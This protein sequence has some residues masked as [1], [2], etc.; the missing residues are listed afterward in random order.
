MKIPVKA[1]EEVG[2]RILVE[3]RIAC[4]RMEVSHIPEPNE[5][6]FN[7]PNISGPEYTKKSAGGLCPQVH[8]Y[9]EHHQH[10]RSPVQPPRQVCGI[11]GK[12]PGFSVKPYNVS[13]AFRQ[14]GDPSESD[15]EPEIDYLVYFL[16]ATLQGLNPEI[17]RL[18][19]VML[20]EMENFA[21]IIAL[22]AQK[23]CIRFH[24]ETTFPVESAGT[25]TSNNRQH[26][27]PTETAEPGGQQHGEPSPSASV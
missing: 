26:Q 14:I 13:Q 2:F 17:D 7:P 21:A 27:L 23:N 24:H 15:Q 8:P 11:Q 25:G 16:G 10:F 6:V 12:C 9:W 3:R 20:N 22:K 1:N 5:P 4:T 18:E 19:I